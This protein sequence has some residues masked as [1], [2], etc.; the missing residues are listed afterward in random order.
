MNFKLATA[1]VATAM[2]MATASPS[3]AQCLGLS[4]AS[5]ALV[6]AD[7]GLRA[8]EAEV[9]ELNGRL[10]RLDAGG[11]ADQTDAGW[12]RSHQQCATVACLRSSYDYRVSGLREWVGI[13]QANSQTERSRAPEPTA[14]LASIKNAETAPVIPNA[15]PAPTR[16]EPQPAD[17]GVS[18]TGTT[19]HPPV[20]QQSPQALNAP[21]PQTAPQ[22]ASSAKGAETRPNAGMGILIF[23]AVV[24]GVALYLLPSII[25]FVRGHS[26]RWIILAIN[27]VIGWSLLG[28]LGPMI[29][30]V[31]P[32]EKALVDPFVGNVTGTGRRTAGDALGVADIGR[33]HGRSEGQRETGRL[34]SFQLDQLERLARL[35]AN[36]VLTDDEFTKERAAILASA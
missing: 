20:A 29:W 22:Q 34:S 19:Q 25:A 12:R 35:K 15:L 7:A 26:Y 36:G 16:A 5:G 21:Y 33:E 2:S 27:G 6:C 28:W 3:I 31:W 30:A 1:L 23:L 11:M 9:Q 32:S 8:Q 14:A 4:G 18:P 17:R 24:V 13:A 10:D